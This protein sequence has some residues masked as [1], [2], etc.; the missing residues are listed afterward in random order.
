MMKRMIIMLIAVGVVLGGVFGFE[1][2]RSMMIAKFFATM[3]QM[4]QTVAT[5]VARTEEWQSHLDA[6]ASLTAEQGGDLSFEVAGIVGALHFKS[7]ADVAAGTPLAQLRDADDVAHLQSLEAA[8][9]LAEI[10]YRRDSRQLRV[11]AVSQAVVD[12]DAATLAGDR[13]QVAQQKA[14]I[15]KKTLV[16]PYAGHLGIR[17]VTL[18]QYVNPGTAVV[19]LQALDP[20]YADFDLPQQTL[21]EL[22]VGLPVTVTVNAYP[23]TRFTGTIRAVAPQVDPSSRTVQVR[24]ELR[25]PDFRLRPG[26]FARVSIDTGAPQSHVT[27]PQTAITYNPF[28]STVYLVAQERGADGKI[29]GVARQSFVVT[30]P[31]RGDQ[32]AILKGVTAGQTVV[33]SGQVKLR[34]GV[35]VT[36]NNSV[37]PTNDVHPHVPDE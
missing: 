19:S 11:H 17:A 20:I 35:P 3:G 28:G 5:T 12:T 33:V 26:M 7:G 34:N 10:T 22:K 4:P 29:H 25:N 18:G 6:V 14:V 37:L 31:T 16:A 27:L 2:F 30:G 21:P 9:R 15:A 13:A 24:A 36:V 23:G 1:A 8:A 32:V